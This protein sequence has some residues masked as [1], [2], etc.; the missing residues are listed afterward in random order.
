[1][2][3][4]QTDGCRQSHGSRERERQRDRQKVQDGGACVFMCL[5]AK[6]LAQVKT[7]DIV[8]TLQALE[9]RPVELPIYQH[10]NVPRF[11]EVAKNINVSWYL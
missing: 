11:D 7:Q 1:M 10:S 6:H 8:R 3:G 5:C 9:G 4:G 2:V